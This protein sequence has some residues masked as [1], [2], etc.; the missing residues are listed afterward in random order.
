[1]KK[2]MIM[3]V[4]VVAGVAAHAAAI[5]WSATQ[6]SKGEGVT[7]TGGQTATYGSGYNA[8]LFLSAS[9][10]AAD[11]SKLVSASSIA[12]ALAKGDTSVLSKAVVQKVTGAAGNIIA[13]QYGSYGTTQADSVKAFMVV[14][15]D[16]V[17]AD[18]TQFAISAEKTVN[19][20]LGA[21]GASPAAFTGFS[22]NAPWQAMNV[23]EPTSG[24]LL[25]LG[26]AGLA[27][28]RRRA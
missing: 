6:I 18:A 13:N 21:S 22:A 19:I 20:S 1:M 7:W 11:A 26:V 28:R 16:D 9:T 23:P 4:A 27:L 8:Y 14:I 12:E 15:N 5:N 2:L 24:L 25:L 10:L 3:A 17:P